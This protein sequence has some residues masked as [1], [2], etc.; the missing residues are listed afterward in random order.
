MRWD[1]LPDVLK[2]AGLPV[3]VLEGAGSRGGSDGIANP[4]VVWHH[5]VTGTNWTTSSVNNL[6]AYKGNATTPPPL[7]N[8]GVERDGTH[9]IVS[10]GVANHA[11]AGGW[12]GLAGNRSMIGFE[13][14]NA[15]TA[16]E[17]FPLAQLDSVRRATAAILFHVKRPSS[18]LCA[19]KE[20]A[21]ARKSDPH[22]LDMDWERSY[23]TSILPGTAPAPVPVPVPYPDLVGTWA[24][25][26][27]RKMIE[28]GIML[29]DGKLWFP[30]RALTRAEFAYLMV[31]KGKEILEVMNGA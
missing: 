17:P 1:W 3:V 5:T 14:F 18:F 25:G 2:S 10:T 4:G 29:G 11:G 26:P 24:E 23:I 15:G 9:Y 19:H 16:A 20:W 6:L 27:A 8:V 13:L 21:P 22:S 30:D 12:N 7:C 28:K 31:V